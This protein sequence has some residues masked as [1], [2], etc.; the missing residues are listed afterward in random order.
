MSIVSRTIYIIMKHVWSGGA[1]SPS[2][3]DACTDS[4][5]ALAEILAAAA[6][7]EFGNLPLELWPGYKRRCRHIDQPEAAP[8]PIHPQ[9]VGLP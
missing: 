7:P 1:N 9:D 4:P 5:I 8:A 6:M 3:A 2:D